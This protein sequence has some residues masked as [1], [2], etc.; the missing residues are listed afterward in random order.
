M[1]HWVAKSALAGAALLAL[2]QIA[3]A[4]VISETESV[5]VTAT[6]WATTL[7]FSGFDT[8]LGTLTKVTITIT[9]DL[10]GTAQA[11]NTGSTSAIGDIS[12]TNVAMLTVPPL[13]VS[14]TTIAATATFTLP[15]GDTS[16]TFPVSNSSTNS[17][18]T[19]TGLSFFE[20]PWSG[21]A[22]NSG[23]ASFDFTSGNALV[24]FTDTGALTVEADYT[25][26]PIIRRSV[27]EPLSTAVFGSG[28][29]ALGLVRRRR[30]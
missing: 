8:T 22:S 19:T 12:L 25:F 20:A 27:P 17:G 21:A 1:M 7:N 10:A 11:M 23:S 3:A 6:N 15:A 24:S 14:T 4:G 29:L 30:R 9:E 26:T 16:P 13:G 18:S 5:P 2:P 28:L